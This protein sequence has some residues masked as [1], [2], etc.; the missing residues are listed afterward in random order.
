MRETLKGPLSFIIIS[1]AFLSLPCS[2]FPPLERDLEDIGPNDVD[3]NGYYTTD[4]GEKIYCPK[5]F[6]EKRKQYAIKKQKERDD[7]RTANGI[8]VIKTV[9]IVIGALAVAYLIYNWLIRPKLP[10]SSTNLT[11]RPPAPL[12]PQPPKPDHLLVPLPELPDT[13]SLKEKQ[14]LDYERYIG[15][16]LEQ[17]GYLVF[18]RGA[19]ANEKDKGVDL[20]ALKDT[21][22]CLIQCKCFNN[23]LLIEQV[24]KYLHH[25][26]Y[27]WENAS[28]SPI[29]G[30]LHTWEL[31]YTSWLSDGAYQTCIDNNITL[32]KQ[33]IGVHP[34]IKAFQFEG[35]R[36]YMQPGQQF[37]DH[38]I[39]YIDGH[40][41]RRFYKSEDAEAAGFSHLSLIDTHT[42]KLINQKTITA[43]AQTYPQT[44][45]EILT[46]PWLNF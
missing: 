33:G 35:K 11:I 15:Y 5:A 46:R 10:Q 23:K 25:I 24:K 36:R 13:P 44:P 26:Q 17:K 32:K 21:Q 16:L 3:W 42:V 39:S 40:D 45:L 37:Y 18:Y 7:L 8:I 28:D 1:F 41:H 12:N 31:Y 38:I 43:Y 20:V 34:L 4:D 2:A 30:I 29:R 6:R 9:C 19:Y 27:E 14:G 22:P